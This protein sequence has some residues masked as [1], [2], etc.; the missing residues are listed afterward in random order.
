MVK[1]FQWQIFVLDILKHLRSAFVFKAEKYYKKHIYHQMSHTLNTQSNANIYVLSCKCKVHRELNLQIKLISKH[2]LVH[3]TV[4][5][6][7]IQPFS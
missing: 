1:G 6:N 7:Q 4:S 3:C 5:Y 2:I